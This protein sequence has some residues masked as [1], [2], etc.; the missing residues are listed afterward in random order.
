MKH[1]IYG[2]ILS[3][4]AV[5]CS[6]EEAIDYPYTEQITTILDSNDQEQEPDTLSILAIGNSFS[7]DAI[8]YLSAIAEGQN[9]GIIIG[10]LS[11]GGCSLEKHLKNITKKN[12]IYDY[13][14]S[15]N[16]QGFYRTK[17]TPAVGLYDEEWDIVSLQQ[18]SAQSGIYRTHVPYAQELKNILCHLLKDTVDFA[19]HQTWAYAHN[20]THEGFA[21]YGYSQDF[22]FRSIA[23][24]SRRIA[25]E[26]DADMVFPV[27]TA[28]QYL[29]ETEVGD[30]LC[31]DGFHL[32]E[33]GRYTA[34][35][36]WFEVLFGTDANTIEYYPA[37]QMTQREAELA[38]AA[39]HQAV[40]SPYGKLPAHNFR[41]RFRN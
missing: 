37:D 14:K 10:N 4:I 22:M 6:Q 21:N 9:V 8:H 35:C 32:N 2:L 40:I 18:N 28:I 36:V 30:S 27:G 24:T 38:R 12:A 7:C 3:V 33:L 31:R 29:R 15:T 20:S 5:G 34:S 11:I 25:T 13:Q 23:R 26:I 1:S 39:A 41:R 16:T 19:W 17:Q